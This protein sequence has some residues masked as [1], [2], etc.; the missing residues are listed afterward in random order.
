M[1]LIHRDLQ[2]IL[3]GLMENVFCLGSKQLFNYTISS[4]QIKSD[5]LPLKLCRYGHFDLAFELDRGLQIRD[6]P[7]C[8]GEKRQIMFLLAC[9]YGRL[10][11]AQHMYAVGG[12]DI[13]H[14][15]RLSRCLCKRSLIPMSVVI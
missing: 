15:N 13:H 12:I 11:V 8:S 6:S 4:L 3:T 5:E 2:W 1:N 9:I 10:D 14:N 7:L